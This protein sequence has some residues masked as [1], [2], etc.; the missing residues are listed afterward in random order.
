MP[1]RALRQREVD[2]PQPR[3]GARRP[4]CWACTR[5]RSSR[6]RPRPRARHGLPGR[7]PLPVAEPPP[8]H[9]VPPAAPEAREAGPRGAERGAAEA[10]PPLALPRPLSPR[11]VGRHAPAGSHRSRPRDGPGGSSDGRT[12]RRA[13]RADTGDPAGRA[14]A[15]L[16]GDP[17]NGRLRDPQRSRGG[18]PRRS[19]RAHGDPSGEDLARGAGRAATPARRG[20]SA[21]RAA[22]PGHRAPHRERGREGGARGG[23]RCVGGSGGSRSWRPS[24]SFGP[25]HPSRVAASALVPGPHGAVLRSLAAGVRDGTLVRGGAYERGAPSRGLRGVARH[26]ST[27]RDRP[28]PS[29]SRQTDHRSRRPRAELRPVH[30]LAPTRHPLVWPERVGHPAR[31]RPRCCHSPSRWRRKTPSDMVPPSIR[32]RGPNHGGSRRAPHALGYAPGGGCPVSSVARSSGGR[33]L[34]ARSWPASFSSFRAVS[35]TCSRRAAT[36]ATPRSFCRS[37]ASSSP[38][39]ARARPC[40]SRAQIARSHGAGVSRA[41]DGRYDRKGLAR[42][43][44]PWRSELPHGQG[45]RSPARGIGRGVRRARSSGDPRRRARERRADPRRKAREG[46]P[47][48]RGAHPPARPR[49]RA[50]RQGRRAP[51]GG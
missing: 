16:A 7:G 29:A 3:S 43:R 4:Q 27:A 40:S 9:R 14:R 17:K 18:A 1:A 42:G 15:Y 49:A 50:R 10:R 2:D 38:W 30:L 8:Q 44:R 28:R 45:A 26:R 5:G 33:S 23:G 22:L 37:S 47:L 25:R 24:S 36:L 39:D 32:A 34:S 13:R 12:V 51:E 35:A 20:G 48:P 31:H 21:R 41:Y 11:A 19:H 6:R 46:V